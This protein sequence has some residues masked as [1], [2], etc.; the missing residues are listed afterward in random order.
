MCKTTVPQLSC[1]LCQQDILQLHPVCRNLS[2][3]CSFEMILVA[4]CS[5]NLQLHQARGRACMGMC[6]FPMHLTRNMHMWESGARV[7][8]RPAH[9]QNYSASTELCTMPAR[10]S[11]AA[12][13]VP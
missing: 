2:Y 5:P 4:L 7:C 10:H 6:N 3:T 13:R 11:S 1:A 8:P 9:V 12:P